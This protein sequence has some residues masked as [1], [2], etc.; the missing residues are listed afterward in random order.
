MNAPVR[1]GEVIK[2]PDLGEVGL[3]G[4]IPLDPSEVPKLHDSC[5]QVLTLQ[6]LRLTNE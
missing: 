2:T 4:S 1:M 5:G 6:V 3:V